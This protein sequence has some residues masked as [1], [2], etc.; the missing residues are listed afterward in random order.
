MTSTEAKNKGIKLTASEEQ[1]ERSREL[2]KKL[3]KK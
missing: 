3:A 1:Y 2:L